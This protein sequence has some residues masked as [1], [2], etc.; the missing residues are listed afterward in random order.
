[1]MAQKSKPFTVSYDGRADVLYITRKSA[2][3]VR[4][5][6]DRFGIVWRYDQ[7]GELIG[8]TIM[9]FNERWFANQE[10]LA[11]ALAGRLAKFDNGFVNK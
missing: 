6:E 2:S 5:T 3:G 4:G 8:A 1:M 7:G 10:E 11:E 9:D